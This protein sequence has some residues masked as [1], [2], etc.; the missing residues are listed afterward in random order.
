MAP[1]KTTAVKELKA[2]KKK[3]FKLEYPTVITVL[4]S[5]E[6]KEYGEYFK[7]ICNHELYGE[8]PE[9]FS[10]RV[11]EMAY[12]MTTRELDYQM[13]K[14]L[15]NREQGK[16][17][18]QGGQKAGSESAGS[19]QQDNNAGTDLLAVLTTTQMQ[20]L[21]AKFPNFSELLDEVQ[22][23]VNNGCIKVK[24]PMNYII[25]YAEETDW[26]SRF[27]KEVDDIAYGIVG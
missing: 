7:A 1:K 23:Q 9:T 15:R 27:D 4:E 17:N 10:N 11:V 16:I 6:E 5:L 18:Q 12:K 19:E 14:H 20:K 24:S 8:E 22:E 26:I 3:Y 21:E 2:P 25:K 13:E